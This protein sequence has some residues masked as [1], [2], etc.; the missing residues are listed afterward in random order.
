M[1]V[2]RFVAIKFFQKIFFQILFK[3]IN[4]NLHQSRAGIGNKLKTH[5]FIEIIAQIITKNTN[6][7]ESVLEMKFTTQI[8][9]ETLWI[10]S[11]LSFWFSGVI[12]F[13]LLCNFLK[14]K[15]KFFSQLINLL[16]QIVHKDLH[17]FFL[18]E[19]ENF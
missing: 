10:A 9:Q 6:Q 3:T 2:S 19:F 14:Y 11:C 4:K 8:G 16:L 7:A 17:K 5:K 1:I 12:I 15:L 13:D 18:F